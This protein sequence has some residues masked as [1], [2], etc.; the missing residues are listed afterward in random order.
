MEDGDNEPT[1]SVEEEHALLNGK[2][3]LISAEANGQSEKPV[4]SVIELVSGQGKI[5]NGP[6]FA[7]LDT[8]YTIDPS[9]RPRSIDVSIK[10]FKTTNK[11]IYRLKGDRLTMVFQGDHKGERPTSFRTKDGEVLNTYE[12]VKP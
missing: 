9:Q 5:D 2:W 7:P 8:T 12:R 3:R 10:Q 1:R 4:V 11:G 6:G